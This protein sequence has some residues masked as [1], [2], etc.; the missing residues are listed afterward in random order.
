MNQISR[1]VRYIRLLSLTAI[2]LRVCFAIALIWIIFVNMDIAV[3]QTNLVPA[4]S[5]QEEQTPEVL[6][7][8]ETSLPSKIKSAIFRDAAR[9]SNQSVSSLTIIKSQPKN[10]SDGCLGLANPD[11]LCTQVITAGWR[12]VVTDGQRNWTYRTDDVGNLVKLEIRNK[13]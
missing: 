5:L 4:P 1:N 11:E 13:K 6:T 12:V 9:R 7:A 8:K 2:T 3:A 10:W